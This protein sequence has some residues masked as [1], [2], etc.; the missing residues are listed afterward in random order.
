MF[1]PVLAQMLTH[2]GRVEGSA[3][4]FGVRVMGCARGRGRGVPDD[5]TES[6]TGGVAERGALPGDIL[7]LRGRCGMSVWSGYV[8]LRDRFASYWHNRDE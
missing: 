4:G 8:R 5:G 3:P 1:A 6:V 2:P 7:E